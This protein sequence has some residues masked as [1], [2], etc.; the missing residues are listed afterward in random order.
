[1]YIYICIYFFFFLQTRNSVIV[2]T[3]FCF[4]TLDLLSICSLFYLF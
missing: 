2:T 3:L 1:M 4:P